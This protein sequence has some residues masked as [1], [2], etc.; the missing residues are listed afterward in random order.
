M[1]DEPS[2]EAL[3]EELA[4][5]RQEVARLRGELRAA[6]GRV[7]LTMKAQRRCPGCGGRTLLHA[8]RVLDRSDAGREAL[9]LA[10]PS[11]WFS[12]G[13]G[14]FEVYVCRACGL[15]E[16]YVKD[17]EALEEHKD[18]FTLIEAPKSENGPYR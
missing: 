16:W 9:A 4:E 13:V 15:C 14:E 1:A 17:L 11:A 2:K 7:A 3:A 18:L 12:R 8:S 5:L 6:S 10:Q